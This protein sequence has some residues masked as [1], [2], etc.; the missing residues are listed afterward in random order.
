MPQCWAGNAS[1]DCQ[2]GCMT[3]CMAQGCLHMLQNNERA[4]LVCPQMDDWSDFVSEVAERCPLGCTGTNCMVALAV[5]SGSRTAGLLGSF[6]HW[7]RQ[8]VLQSNR[9]LQVRR[10]CSAKVHKSSLLT[11]SGC[12]AN[13]ISRTWPSELPERLQRS[14]YCPSRRGESPSRRQVGQ[15]KAPAMERAGMPCARRVGGV[16]GR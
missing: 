7:P 10:C 1:E 8:A 2:N 13:G 12:R 11:T 15:S 16:A 6:L 5:P 4:N 3:R 14:P 9:F